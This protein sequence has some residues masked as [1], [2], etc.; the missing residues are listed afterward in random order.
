MNVL[1]N[2]HAA[3][4]IA[5]LSVPAEGDQP[6]TSQF[7]I[8]VSKHETRLKKTIN[9]EIDTPIPDIRLTK[10]TKLTQK[11]CRTSSKEI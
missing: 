3:V 5:H 1:F 11:K 4:T 10:F 6:I 2:K 9:K 8:G 7:N